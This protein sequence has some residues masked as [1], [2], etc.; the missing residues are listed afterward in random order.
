[1]DPHANIARQREL[2]SSIIF[3]HE[4]GLTM[5]QCE[6]AAELAE[7]VIALDNWRLIGGFGPYKD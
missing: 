5:D 7:L 2:A 6:D 1:M 4:N 3:R